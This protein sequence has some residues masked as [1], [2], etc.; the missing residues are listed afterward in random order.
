MEHSRV[1]HSRRVS[2]LPGAGG[3]GRGCIGDPLHHRIGL[4]RRN[5]GVHGICQIYI[6]VIPV[7]QPQR[8]TQIDVFKHG[9]R[10]AGVFVHVHVPQKVRDNGC[11]FQIIRFCAAQNILYQ[12]GRNG[13]GQD[14]PV[15]A[16][17]FAPAAEDL[18]GI[19]ASGILL[20]HRDID[21]IQ[22]P[23]PVSAGKHLAVSAKVQQGAPGKGRDHGIAADLHLRSVSGK[24][25]EQCVFKHQRG[26]GGLAP[27][28]LQQAAVMLRL[29]HR[30]EI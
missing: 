20:E 25:A 27:A 26:H 1:H 13:I 29:A 19:P 22:P 3:R 11:G 9:Y 28:S 18:S 21:G 10:G 2:L 30:A 5:N 15:S 17:F 14:Q 12:E 16:I 7:L 23:A 4:I 24:A 8:R 6:T